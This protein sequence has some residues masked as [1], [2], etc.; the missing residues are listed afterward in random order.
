M[1]IGEASGQP[2]AWAVRELIGY[3]ALG[4]DSTWWEVLEAEPEGIPERAHQFYDDV[5]TFAFAPYFDLYGG[6]GIVSTVGDLTR[7]YRAVLTGGVFV[8]PS[9]TTTMLSTVDGAVPLP[10]AGPVGYRMGIWVAD[11][12]GFTTYM[13]SGFFGTAAAY[14]PELDLAVSTTV[15]QHQAREAM[16]RLIEEAVRSVAAMT[17]QTSG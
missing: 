4:L 8:D 15:N 2:L 16:Y 9:T 13:H 7:F 10:D 14:V 11:V 1:A 5:D 17:Q 3:D 12:D 6:G